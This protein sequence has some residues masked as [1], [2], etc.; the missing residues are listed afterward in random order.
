MLSSIIIHLSLSS[1]IVICEGGREFQECGSPCLPQTCDNIME[2]DRCSLLGPRCSA[3]CFCP[4]GKVLH[5]NTC[6]PVTECP[7]E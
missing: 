7:S 4:E 6:I 3:G 1:A 2:I 5:N